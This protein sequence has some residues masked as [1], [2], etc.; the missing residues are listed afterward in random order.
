M[1]SGFGL[2]WAIAE[3]I[4]GQ[5]THDQA[6]ALWDAALRLK[7]KAHIV[8]IGSY[9]G[10]ATVILGMAAELVGARV[11]AVEPFADGGTDREQFEANIAVAELKDVVT[12]LAEPSAAVRSSWTDPIDLLYIDGKH[13]SGAF[14]ND[15]RWSL[16]LA[17][18][19]EML[20]HDCFSSI[21]VTA[22]VLTRVLTSRR[23]TYRSRVGSLARFQLKSPSFA[24]RLLILR[25]LPWFAR[26]I[27]VKVS[28]KVRRLDI[29][30]RLGHHTLENPY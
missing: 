28:L 21:G 22:G 17:P 16:M 8:E 12:L 30:A 7:K 13:Q 25:Q 4:P 26:N 11:T 15:L 10:R 2:A 1:L 29:A 14:R 6:E 23:Y 3:K 9:Q 19:A 5:L 24:E 27:V 18:G 20:V